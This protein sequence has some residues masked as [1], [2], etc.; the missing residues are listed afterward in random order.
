[1]DKVNWVIP[2]E[3]PVSMGSL[4][5][6]LHGLEPLPIRG[7]YDSGYYISPSSDGAIVGAIHPVGLLGITGWVPAVW[8]DVPSA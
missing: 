4:P 8:L 1:M 3:I 7:A 5:T 6:L 2:H